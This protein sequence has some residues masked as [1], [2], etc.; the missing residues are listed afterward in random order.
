VGITYHG[1]HTNVI[2]DF[3]VSKIDSTLVYIMN[4]SFQCL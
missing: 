1:F 4:S 3:I 2:L